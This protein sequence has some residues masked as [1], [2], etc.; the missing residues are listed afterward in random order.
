M[1]TYTNNVLINGTTGNNVLQATDTLAL[2]L[3]TVVPGGT[4][5]LTGAT[6]VG[7]TVPA[8]ATI[9][10]GVGTFGFL[11]TPGALSATALTTVTIAGGTNS[12]VSISSAGTG[13]LALVGTGGTLWGDAL[14]R[15]L[16]FDGT[17][18]LSSSSITGINLQGGS[19]SAVALKSTG[20][21]TL[22][23]Q[24][25]TG[26]A[27]YGDGTAQLHFNGSGAFSTLGFTTADYDASGAV[28]F[29]SSAGTLSFGNDANNQ[30]MFYGTAGI[31]TLTFG[32]TTAT[33]QVN[34]SG[35]T[36]ATVVKG[37][38]TTS[39]TL[40]DGTNTLESL[41]TVNFVE[42]NSLVIGF[43]GGT[44]ATPT[45]IAGI[46]TAGAAL[47]IGD[48]VYRA[49]TTGKFAKADNAT[50]GKKS[51]IGVTVRSAAGD[52]STAYIARNGEKAP[53][54]LDFTPIASEIGVTP[55]YLG[56]G[57][58]GTK[59]KPTTAGTRA[60]ILGILAT[61]SGTTLEFVDLQMQYLSDN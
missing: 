27:D 44:T 35:G 60:Y 12:L 26:A 51:P 56:T 34:S 6:V 13:Q 58:Q 40:T 45:G 31:R 36:Y 21:G 37:N 23:V 16:S 30:N 1:A 2:N 33:I 49:A 61:A 18:G 9:S 5:T 8:G 57:G 14:G 59:T 29:N 48:V 50:A 55:I 17:G 22:A 46:E 15:G 10:D 52:G 43:T 38:A 47:A 19:G 25:A 20:A 32:S 41:N 7:L 24:S 28:Q 39:A 42:T 4:L 53:V 54:Q 11:S 3:L